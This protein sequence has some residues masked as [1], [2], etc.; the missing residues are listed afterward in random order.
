MERHESM[1]LSWRNRVTGVKDA[2][3][4]PIKILVVDDEESIRTF[5][6]RVLESA[7]YV[8]STAAS[9]QEAIQAVADV[10]VPDLLLT[11]LTL[12]G[13]DGDDLAAKLRVENRDLRVLYLTGFSEHLFTQ[14]GVLWEGEAFLDKPCN[15][16]GLL[17]GV[18][19]LLNGRTLPAAPAV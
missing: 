12:P 18:S 16:K 7:G 15:I 11:D 9:G 8:T 19:M 4:A 17:E 2:A 13:M 5:V 10:G 6:K 14:K 1:L 3:Q